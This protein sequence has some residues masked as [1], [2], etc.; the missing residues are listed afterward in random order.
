[1]HKHGR[2]TGVIGLTVGLYRADVVPL[3]AVAAIGAP[4]TL[5]T[6]LTF[7]ALMSDPS[8]TGSSLGVIIRSDSSGT[9]AG[10]ALP[11]LAAGLI[12]IL[13]G[14]WA[15]ATMVSMLVGHVRS[16][17]RARL[18]DL[19]CGLQYWAWAALAALIVK[20]VDT[21]LNTVGALIL[22]GAVT[23]A[24]LVSLLIVLLVGTAV[25]FSVQEIVDLGR[26]GAAALLESWRLVRR[27][28][29]W[30]VLIT[31][32]LGSICL[33][34][35]LFV[36]VFAT[37]VLLPVASRV[38][39]TSFVTAVIIGPLAAAFVTVMYFLA[40]DARERFAVVLLRGGPPPAPPRTSA[41]GRPV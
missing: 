10:W 33:L 36:E 29:F 39:V 38:V 30:Q 26:N 32:V 2:F 11:A 31:F 40:Q 9:H 1:M 41:P 4:V 16:G 5:A 19:G 7:R 18:G 6:T 15:S 28:G 37:T 23:P 34:P 8:V 12:G 24:R 27:A 13:A 25:V 3:V 35:I 20:L 17:R 22:P 21:G 14:A